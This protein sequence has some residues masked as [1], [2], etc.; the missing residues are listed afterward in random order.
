MKERETPLIEFPT[1]IK[2]IDCG[3][4]KSYEGPNMRSETKHNGNAN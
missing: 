4:L 3:K 1:N 2:G